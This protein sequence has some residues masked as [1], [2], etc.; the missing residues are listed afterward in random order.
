VFFIG[1]GNA[2]AILV[3]HRI[4]EEDVHQAFRYAARTLVIAF[5]GGV[6]IGSMILLTADSILSLYKVSPSVIFYASRAL[7]ISALILWLRASNMVLFVGI[8]RSGGDT[9]FAF[10]LDGLII[11]IVGVPLAYIGAFVFN[12]PVYWVYLLVMSEEFLKWFFGMFRFISRKW[13]HNVAQT[14][15][16]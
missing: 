7:T 14:V 15:E 16:L 2:C 8:F 11:W 13:I 6:V 5:L 10:L 9:R 12:L 4:G 3:G 1:I